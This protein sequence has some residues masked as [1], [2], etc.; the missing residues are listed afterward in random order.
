MRDYFVVINSIMLDSL[1]SFMDF[2]KINLSGI[3]I[4]NG[5]KL[6]VRLNEKQIPSCDFSKLR[7][8]VESATPPHVR[9]DTF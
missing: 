5:D 6:D 3:V 8:L 1:S 2:S 9:R 7:Y 4:E